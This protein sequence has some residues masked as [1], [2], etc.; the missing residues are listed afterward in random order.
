M[1]NKTVI[2]YLVQR[3]YAGLS[4]LFLKQINVSNEKLNY[5]ASYRY[6]EDNLLTD[7]QVLSRAFSHFNEWNLQRLNNLT[8]LDETRKHN[9]SIND[10]VKIDQAF[11]QCCMVCWKRLN[12][13]DVILLR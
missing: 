2:I 7:E 10:V 11:Y 12:E 4:D 13:N 8:V 3:E 6:Q 9:L 1:N 5:V